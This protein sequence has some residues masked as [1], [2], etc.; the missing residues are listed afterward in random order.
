MT[1]IL[2]K[3]ETYYLFKVF[4]FQKTNKKMFIFDLK[5]KV[6]KESLS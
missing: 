6:R 4:F 2:K 1:A 5:E 3:Y